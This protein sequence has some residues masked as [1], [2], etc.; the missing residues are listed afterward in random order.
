MSYGDNTPMEYGKPVP[1]LFAPEKHEKGFRK[2]RPKEQNYKKI[3]L[4]GT[5]KQ[6]QE[7][8]KIAS[9]PQKPDNAVPMHEGTQL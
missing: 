7:K 5:E 2:H 1:E 6:A 9:T 3:S 4:T 8:Q